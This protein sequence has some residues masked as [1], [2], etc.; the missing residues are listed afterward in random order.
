MLAT[1]A[2]TAWQLL[3]GSPVVDIAA[4]GAI[5]TSIGHQPDAV[6]VAPADDLE[7]GMLHLGQRLKV[8]L[9]I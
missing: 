1:P 2:V 5:I 4:I 8:C 7:V 3:T 9:D 6:T